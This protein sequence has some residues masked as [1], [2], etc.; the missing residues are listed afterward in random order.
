MHQVD[1]DSVED[2]DSKD[3]KIHRDRRERKELLDSVYSQCNTKQIKGGL[4]SED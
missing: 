1:Q 3:T 2:K 4:N